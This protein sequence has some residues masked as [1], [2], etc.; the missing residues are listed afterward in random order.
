MV[1][2]QIEIKRWSMTKE[3][4]FYSYKT[5]TEGQLQRA[6]L[7]SGRGGHLC[8]AASNPLAMVRSIDNGITINWRNLKFIYNHNTCPSR[9]GWR[10]HSS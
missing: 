7:E 2:E 3:A 5:Q 9:T 1:K 4:F 10:E 6:F 8:V